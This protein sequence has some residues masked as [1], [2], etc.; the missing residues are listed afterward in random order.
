MNSRI[1]A[2]K[3]KLIR[4]NFDQATASTS[5]RS[6]SLT[7]GPLTHDNYSVVTPK[8]MASG[9]K[10][11]WGNPNM[12]VDHS[13]GALSYSTH[14]KSGKALFINMSNPNPQ[15]GDLP[16]AARL[17]N[18]YMAE[19]NKRNGITIAGFPGMWDNGVHHRFGKRID[20]EGH[21]QGIREIG[22]EYLK[23]IQDK[24]VRTE[25]DFM[26]KRE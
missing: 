2:L 25:R 23:E 17:T 9:Q 1:K 26:D 11:K 20:F 19:T 22:A 24:M 3:N 13:Q 7:K 10:A 14:Q 6:L 18:A 16:Y 4:E 21:T 15:N 5:G 8:T 12:S